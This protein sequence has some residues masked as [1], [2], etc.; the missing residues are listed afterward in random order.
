[1]RRAQIDSFAESGLRTLVLGMRPLSDDEYM[2]WLG[3][4][5]EANAA[6]ENRQAK[7]EACYD[8]LERNFELIG[9][10]AIEDRLQVRC[11]LPLRAAVRAASL[12]CCPALLTRGLVVACCVQRGVPETIAVLSKAGVRFWMC[13]GDKF[14]TALTIAQTCN[15][16]QKDYDL[17]EV[18]GKDAAAV[19]YCGGCLTASRR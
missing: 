17:I 12:R 9:A 14:S 8:V 10:T 13:T 18:V 5:E 19:S 11:A 16:K 15:L 7:K 1:L 2:R 3:T 6:M 4:F